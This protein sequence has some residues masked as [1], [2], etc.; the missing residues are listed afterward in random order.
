MKYPYPI[1]HLPS[2]L[3]SSGKRRESFGPR[4]HFR[5]QREEGRSKDPL[6]VIFN[7]I[8]WISSGVPRRRKPSFKPCPDIP[9]GLDA[10]LETFSSFIS[11]WWASLQGKRKE[12][13]FVQRN[14]TRALRSQPQPILWPDLLASSQISHGGHA[15][16]QAAEV[17]RGGGEDQHTI[18]QPKKEGAE[19]KEPSHLPLSYSPCV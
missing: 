18:F 16:R 9:P 15:V 6:L 3:L 7:I 12:R 17:G 13:V 11:P 4:S 10:F 8:S 19:Y 2:V 5:R 1:S 14:F